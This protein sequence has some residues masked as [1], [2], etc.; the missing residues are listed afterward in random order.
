[1]SRRTIENCSVVKKVARIGL[2]EPETQS[3]KCLGYAGG[4]GPDDDEPCEE[5]KVCKLNTTFEELNK[6]YYF[7]DPER[8]GGLFIAAKTWKE[9]RNI[10]LTG[11]YDMLAYISFTEI[12]GELLK[13][14]DGNPYTTELHGQLELYQLDELGIPYTQVN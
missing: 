6:V 14:K 7:C 1:M 4:Y 3:G 12:E 13:D 10:S 9:A 5:C 8:D 2:G 11:D